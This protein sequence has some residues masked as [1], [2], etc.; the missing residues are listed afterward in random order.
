[1][2]RTWTAAVAASILLLVAGC[3]PGSEDA[4]YDAF[5]DDTPPPTTTSEPTPPGE[6]VLTLGPTTLGEVV[7]D[8]GGLTVYVYDA[9][10]VGSATSTCTGPCLESWEPVT[11]STTEPLV[12]GLEDTVVVET[13]PS[14]DAHQIVVNGRPVYRSTGD[15]EPGDAFGQAVGDTW[16]ALDRSGLA[17]TGEPDE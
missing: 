7:V 16:W 14:G 9:D 6:P 11:S 17:V 4:G 1:M 2:Y 8:A 12:E 5:D 15:R 13:I 10:E 3:S